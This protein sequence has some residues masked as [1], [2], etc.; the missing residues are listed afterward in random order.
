[1]TEV[2]VNLL[3]KISTIGVHHSP[4]SNLWGSF[5]LPQHV[6]SSTFARESVRSPFW[7]EFR[8]FRSGKILVIFCL[9]TYHLDV[10]ALM[11]HGVF[12]NKRFCMKYSYDDVEALNWHPKTHFV[13]VLQINLLIPWQLSQRCRSQCDIL[14]NESE[15]SE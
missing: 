5:F 4:V 8:Y 9:V 15:I 10:I 13:S 12:C 2:L 3:L 7:I 11:K 6:S 14:L 1:M